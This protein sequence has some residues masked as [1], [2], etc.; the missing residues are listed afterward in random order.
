MRA[1]NTVLA[2]LVVAAVSATAFGTYQFGRQQS[3]EIADPIQIKLGETL[4]E[5]PGRYSPSL[6]VR[7][8]QRKPER[9]F[10]DHY[11]GKLRHVYCHSK[12][13]EPIEVSSVILNNSSMEFISEDD[14][15]NLLSGVSVL[16]IAMGNFRLNTDEPFE[17]QQSEIELGGERFIKV[18]RNVAHSKFNLFSFTKN[19]T[20][21]NYW[22]ACEES[23]FGVVGCELHSKTEIPG[24]ESRTSFIIDPGYRGNWQG[25]IYS[26]N[27]F[28]E[29]NASINALIRS[30]SNTN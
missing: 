18:G 13:D 6:I 9:K 11:E 25:R 14:T 12:S 17:G 16:S 19:S 4:M 5:I 30:F 29:L 26:L 24:F 20:S 21:V 10:S 3:C 23:F 7:Y 2:L 8:G 28:P 1:S 27:E 15:Y 22:A